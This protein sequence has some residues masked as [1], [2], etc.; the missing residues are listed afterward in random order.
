MRGALFEAGQ[1]AALAENVSLQ[2]V[3]VGQHGDDDFCRANRLNA[4][5]R[6]R[7]ETHQ[8]FGLA[9]GSIV[10]ADLVARFEQ[11]RRHGGTHLPEANESDFHSSASSVVRVERSIAGRKAASRPISRSAQR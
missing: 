8:R 10:D 4:A 1:Y 6:L 3:V 11:I 7:A 9:G 5:L 2:R